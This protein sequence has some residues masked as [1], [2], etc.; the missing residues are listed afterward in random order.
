M[1]LDP[2]GGDDRK[3]TPKKDI[4][5]A[6][7]E[8][9]IVLPNLVIRW[10]GSTQSENLTVIVRLPA[11][12]LRK[13][14]PGSGLKTYVTAYIENPRTATIAMDLTDD[15]IFDPHRFYEKFWAKAKFGTEHVKVVRHHTAIRNVKNNDP[16]KRI[17][18]KCRINLP[19]DVELQWNTDVPKDEQLVM[20]KIG[21]E[22]SQEH[23]VV[24]EMKEARSK[25]FKSHSVADAWDTCFDDE[26]KAGEA[27]DELSEGEEV[28]VAAAKSNKTEDMDVDREFKKRKSFVVESDRLANLRKF[29]D[30]QLQLQ[31]KRDAMTP[32]QPLKSL[33]GQLKNDGDPADGQTTTNH[34]KPTISSP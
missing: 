15:S 30:Q 29:A 11:G 34:A 25:E 3:E 21:T 10:M 14:A 23:Y 24:M 1:N 9:P 19:F 33:P 17:V 7:S 31:K 27:E 26:G 4:K 12:A 16:H 6:D 18:R 13:P 5:K 32:A 28:T 8:D 20:L 2:K 22:G